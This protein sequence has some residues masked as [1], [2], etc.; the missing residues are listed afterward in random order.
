MP[1]KYHIMTKR[2]TSLLL[3][4]G[5]KRN[6]CNGCRTEIRIGDTYA[7]HSGGKRKSKR[8]CKRCVGKFGIEVTV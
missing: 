4:K 5:N 7:G 6:L 2:L 3:N 8:Y 1:F